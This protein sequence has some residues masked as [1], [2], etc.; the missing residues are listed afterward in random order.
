MIHA[1]ID[2]AA[3]IRELNPDPRV[4]GRTQSQSMEQELYRNLLLVFRII[5][6]FRTVQTQVLS[7]Q[8]CLIYNLLKD[9]MHQNSRTVN[10]EA[11]IS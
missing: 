7:I 9:G 6:L 4:P 11:C 8:T 10:P 5:T 3:G 2:Q 1:A